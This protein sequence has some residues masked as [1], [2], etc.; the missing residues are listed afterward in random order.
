MITTSVMRK[1][2]ESVH[3]VSNKELSD[4]LIEYIHLCRKAKEQEEPRPKIPEFLGKC[5]LQMATRFSYSPNYVNYPFI[6]DLISDAVENCCRYCHNYNP[7]FVSLRTG[8]KLNAFNYITQIIY[9]AFIRRIK[10][11]KRELEKTNKILE[12]LNFEQVMTDEGEG[13]EN[14]SDY[15]SIKDNV[16]SKLRR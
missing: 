2:K 8:K 12:R 16:Y 10:L 3:Y 7:D 14:Y 9:Y 4:A 11:E 5:F 6:N 15:N 13:L 1:R